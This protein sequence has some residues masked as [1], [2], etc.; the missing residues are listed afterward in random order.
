MKANQLIGHGVPGIM[1]MREL[2][3]PKPGPLEV[4]VRV[5]AC[6]L[7]RLDLWAEQ[8]ALPVSI[9][10]PRTLGCEIAGEIEALG[11]SVTNHW[12]VGDPV[13]VQSNLFCGECEFCLR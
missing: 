8:G 3:D 5:R 12:E 4:V 9:Q 7:N 11:E 10:L 6:G 13:A 1:E 2:P